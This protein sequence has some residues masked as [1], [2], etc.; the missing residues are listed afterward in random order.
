MSQPTV[1]PYTG[2]P[3]G[4]PYDVGLSPQELL[5]SGLPARNISVANLLAQLQGPSFESLYAAP[6]A[7]QLAQQYRAGQGSIAGA[8]QQR[9]LQQSGLADIERRGLLNLFSQGMLTNTAQAAAQEDQRRQALINALLGI[10]QQDLQSLQAI[11]TGNLQASGADIAQNAV[12]L[13]SI[14]DLGVGSATIASLLAGGALGG[15][16]A[17]S[18]LGGQ[19]GALAGTQTGNLLSSGST[20]GGAVGGLSLFGGIGSGLQGGGGGLNMTGGTEMS[21]LMSSLYG[22]SGAGGGYTPSPYGPYLPNYSFPTYTAPP[23][24]SS[25]IYAGGGGYQ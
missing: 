19:G 13:Q 1:N 10:G 5:G 14:K 2:I 6:G 24:E 21:P 12:R 11:G 22:T 25:F 23:A 3:T 7:D 15:S 18:G 17:L 8:L 9:G 4:S 20:A 16:G